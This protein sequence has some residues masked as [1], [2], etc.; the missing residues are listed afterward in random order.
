MLLGVGYGYISFFLHKNYRIM[1]G[2][3]RGIELLRCVCGGVWNRC[4]DQIT[5]EVD[6]VSHPNGSKC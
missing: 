3:N 4:S 5:G 6:L 2:I 1:K